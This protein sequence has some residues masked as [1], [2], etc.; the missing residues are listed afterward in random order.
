VYRDAL[1]SDAHENAGA[2]FGAAESAGIIVP[3]VLLACR[4]AISGNGLRPS[5]APFRFFRRQFFQSTYQPLHSLALGLQ[6]CN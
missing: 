6:F 2:G 4:I 3:A 5:L 1:L